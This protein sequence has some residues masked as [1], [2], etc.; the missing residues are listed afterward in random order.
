MYNRA[1]RVA[2]AAL[3]AI[4]GNIEDQEAFRNELRNMV[5]ENDTVSSVIYFDEYQHAVMDVFINEVRLIDD[6][7]VNYPIEVFD[8]SQPIWGQRS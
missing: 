4:N 1:T 2:I 3:E 8:R 5:F 6:E 7:W